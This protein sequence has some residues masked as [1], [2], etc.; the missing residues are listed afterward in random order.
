MLS[1][2]LYLMPVSM[3]RSG[4][5]EAANAQLLRTL[6]NLRSSQARQRLA[7][8]WRHNCLDQSG[9]AK[10]KNVRLRFFG[11]VNYDVC[12]VLGC[13]ILGCREMKCLLSSRVHTEHS[14]IKQGYKY[15]PDYSV[16]ECNVFSSFS[17][18]TLAIFIFREMDAAKMY[19]IWITMIVY[20]MTFN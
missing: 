5:S 17:Q 16:R 20:T 12:C 7:S 10:P 18:E 14:K 1:F 4:C 19:L 3:F 2:N 13:E 11:W 9:L 8:Y 6:V 15:N